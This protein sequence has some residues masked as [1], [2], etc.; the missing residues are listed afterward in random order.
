MLHEKIG[1]N[2]FCP[3]GSRLKYK[4]CCLSA[5]AHTFIPEDD[6][7]QMKQ[8]LQNLEEKIKTHCGKRA[9]IKKEPVPIKMSEVILEFADDFFTAVLVLQQLF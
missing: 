5:P 4:K 2:A 1:R 8:S 9:Q 6:S 3:C 7:I